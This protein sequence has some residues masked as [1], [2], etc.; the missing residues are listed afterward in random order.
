MLIDAK[1]TKISLNPNPEEYVITYKLE[2]HEIRDTP[3]ITGYLYNSLLTITIE[4][5]TTF[6]SSIVD[7]FILR[8][9]LKSN[10]IFRLNLTENGLNV[11]KKFME[12]RQNILD[13]KE[14]SLN[15]Q[16]KT[17]L[18]STPFTDQKS[19]IAF[20]IARRRG[21]NCSSVGV[22][23]TL[24][25]LG[26]FNQ[27]F[28]SKLVRQGAIFCLNENKLTWYNE[29]LKHTNY[30]YKIVRNGSENVCNDID[31][32][33]GQL[34]VL[35]YDCI[36]NEDVKAAL[37]RAGFDFWTL[38]EAHTLRNVDKKQRQKVKGQP[39]AFKYVPASQ[40][41]N[42]IFE[43]CSVIDPT[44][45]LLLTG[46]PIP[47][48][49]IHAYAIVKL[50]QPSWVT[51]RARFEDHFCNFVEIPMKKFSKRKIKILNKKN[52]YKNLDQLKFMLDLL[53][54]RRTQD[55][56]KD[57]P[58]TMLSIKEFEIEPPQKAF[59]DAIKNKEMQR[60]AGKK[61]RS[62]ETAFVETLRLRQCLSNPCILDDSAASTKMIVL[63]QLVEEILSDP[64]NKIV[65]FSC[66]RPT[67]E[68]ITKKYKDYNAVMFAGI[69]KDLKQEDRDGNIT[70]FLTDPTCRLL[71]ANSSLGAGGNWGQIARY[72][73]FYDLPET[74]L[75]WKQSFGRI[76]R[77]DA[78][79][80]SNII[81]MLSTGTCE[82]KLWNALDDKN[83]V[84]DSI[85]G[86]DQE[87]DLDVESILQD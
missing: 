58:P 49:P 12:H 31:N 75:D 46:T 85:L 36:I 70:R 29:I 38:D 60:L 35:H 28:E 77:R 53:A 40:R 32:F 81:V 61:F 11:C 44:Y 18:K 21:L 13:I 7:F 16:V 25:A 48:D 79:G 73:I 30:T 59:Y 39:K 9:L 23:K 86:K 68:I 83:E 72:G 65:V 3:K 6:K 4:D 50:L 47:E 14:G 82:K 56:C 69:T 19:A 66:F 76:T 57:F 80:T 15:D 74:R 54:F 2:P 67:L 64:R 51:T 17:T 37:I 8:N 42:T 87:F 33:E 84:M 41:A 63:D 1:T 10:P 27:L 5:S 34:L 26:A 71:A 45:V 43:L 78:V 20:F 55:D 52:P 24:S 22:G 62:L